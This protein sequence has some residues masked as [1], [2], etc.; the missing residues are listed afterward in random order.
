[1]STKSPIIAPCIKK[2]IIQFYMNITYQK[3]A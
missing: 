1:M 3:G 2:Y